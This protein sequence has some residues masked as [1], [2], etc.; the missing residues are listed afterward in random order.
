MYDICHTSSSLQQPLLMGNWDQRNVSTT[1]IIY[2]KED[3][4]NGLNESN[5]CF[6]KNATKKEQYSA[7]T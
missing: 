6:L 4:P 3:I 2:R 5:K 7:C 1:A